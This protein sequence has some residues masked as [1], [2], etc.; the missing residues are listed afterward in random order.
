VTREHLD[1]VIVGAGL[2]GVAAAYH[3]QTLCP[4]KTYA[5]F[6]ARD[7]LGGTWDLF[8]YPGIRSD[9]DMYTLG[10]SFRPWRNAKAIADGPSILDYIRETAD[11]YGITPKIRYRR[12]VEDVRWSTAEARWTLDVRDSTSGELTQVTCGFLLLCSGYYEYDEGYTPEFVGRERFGGLIIH[13]QHWPNDLDYA[14]KRIVVIGSGATAVTLVPELAKTAGHVTMLQRSPTYVFTLP[15]R[16]PVADW[17]RGHL[18]DRFAHS[19]VRWKN[20]LIAMAFYNYSRRFPEHAK[21][22]LIRGVDK[23]L[24]GVV[25]VGKHFT[26]SYNPWDQRLCFVPDADLFEALRVGSASMVTDHIAT[27]TETGIQ[28]RSGE[29]LQADIIVTATGLK[30]KMLSG[31]SPEVDGRRIKAAEMLIYKGVMCSDVPNL[32]FAIGYTNASWTLKADLTAQ[33][34]ARLIAHMDEHGYRWCCPR[35]DPSV[36]DEPV[37]D[38]TS[39]YVQRALD[40]LPR[41][42]DVKP[43]RLFQ[44]YA[45]DLLLIKHSR[46]ADNTMQFG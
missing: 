8:R 10:Y 24:R 11:E 45:L 9:S 31:F 1:V 38:F 19:A 16:D 30:M 44:N 7:R 14:G 17:L 32:A 3:V 22:L 26:P 25:D 15:A 43:W 6:E 23:H 46:L 13:P 36:H 12:R 2:S 35:R 18:P 29:H 41:Q 28:L 33:Y 42:G 5:I 39:G 37:L 34:A 40:M 27:F 20:V 21:R 4:A